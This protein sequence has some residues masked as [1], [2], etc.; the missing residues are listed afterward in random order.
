MECNN[1]LQQLTLAIRLLAATNREVMSADDVAV[2]TGLSLATVR[3]WAATGEV[4]S[5]RKGRNLWFKRPDIDGFLLGNR[6]ASNDDIS[7]LAD[8]YLRGN[9]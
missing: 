9:F 7:R 5:Y 2:Y 4:A 8:E 1:T 3:Q 6:R